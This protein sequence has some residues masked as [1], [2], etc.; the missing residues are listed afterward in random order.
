MEAVGKGS[1][2]FRV[3]VGG[4]LIALGL[5]LIA[6]GMSESWFTVLAPDKDQIANYHFGSEAML[7]HGGWTY[8]NPELYGWSALA[9]LGFGGL[10]VAVVGVGLLRASWRIALSGIALW[11]LVVVAMQYLGRQEWERRPTVRETLAPA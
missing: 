4:L 7:A 11:L 1:R 9:S 3:G 2:Y 6:L 5:I 8:A 10:A